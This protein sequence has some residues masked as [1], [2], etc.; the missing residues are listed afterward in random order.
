MWY[1][2]FPEK[3]YYYMYD[4]FISLRNNLKVRSYSGIRGV[5]VYS[6][7]DT[8]IFKTTAVFQIEQN[9]INYDHKVF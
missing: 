2:V 4:S 9:E 1:I 6:K 5:P 8:I 7:V 3:C